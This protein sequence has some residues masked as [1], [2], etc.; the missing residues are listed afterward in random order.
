MYQPTNAFIHSLGMVLNGII[1]KRWQGKYVLILLREGAKNPWGCVPSPFS[2]AHT[3][4]L[5][6][7]EDCLV[8]LSIKIFFFKSKH[9]FREFIYYPK[10]HYVIK[11]VQKGGSIYPQALKF[12]PKLKKI[13]PSP[14]FLKIYPHPLNFSKII[15]PQSF[16]KGQFIPYP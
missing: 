1:M 16:K 15:Y 7:Y 5:P 11:G 14:Y 6:I 8:P 13:S 2:V 3:Y 10:R 4:T 12:C 9:S